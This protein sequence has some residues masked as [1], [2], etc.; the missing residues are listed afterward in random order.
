MS[1]EE[2]IPIGRIT[3][4]HGIKG[5][6]KLAPYGPLDELPLET[7]YING[8][9]GE[10][11]PRKVI[12]HRVHKGAYLL[13]LEGVPD[14]NTAETLAGREVSV[15]KS[16]LPE[17]GEDEYYHADLIGMEVFTEEGKYIGLVE[18]IF[19]TGGNDVIEASGPFGDVLIPVIESVIIRIEPE[20]RKIT[21]RLMEGLLPE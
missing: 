11:E 15:K 14:R 19:A 2:L 13:F 4:A 20:K 9:G 3:G 12:S 1:K 16:D 17:A 8:P 7:V 6:V 21:V 5:E 10:A 18:G